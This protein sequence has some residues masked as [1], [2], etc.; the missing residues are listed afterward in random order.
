[1]IHCWR[2]ILTGYTGSD[3]RLQGE[4]PCLRKHWPGPW[5]DII[6]AGARWWDL[7]EKRDCDRDDNYGYPIPASYLIWLVWIRRW[8]F[9]CDWHTYPTLIE[10]GKGWIF[11]P[12]TG[13]PIGARYFTTVIILDCEQVKM[14][15]FCYIDYDLFW[16]LNFVARLSQ[17]FVEY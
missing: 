9:T 17:I 6:M 8:F 15:S 2:Q 11:F 14:C 1:M 5:R 13:N 4:K 12:L 16:L 10:V 7:K 3:L